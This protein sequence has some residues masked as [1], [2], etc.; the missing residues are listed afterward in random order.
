[1]ATFTKLKSGSWRVQVRRKGRYVGETFLRRED[2]RVWA[3]E[4]ERTIDQGR[5]PARSRTARLKTFGELIDLHISDMKDVGK[6]PGRSKAAT[7]KMLKRR[8]GSLDMQDI[9]R[10]RIVAFGR[11]RAKEGAGPVTTSM[12]IS[13]S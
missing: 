12:D 11:K 6:A 13:A 9:N 8:L 3:T 5:P 1:M 2:A 7:L 10:E 4:A